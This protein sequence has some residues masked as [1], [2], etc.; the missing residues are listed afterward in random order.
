[1]FINKHNNFINFMYM[2]IAWRLLGCRVRFSASV[3]AT[4]AAALTEQ[5]IVRSVRA[6][7][8]ASEKSRLLKGASSSSEG[9]S[10]LLRAH[11]HS[12]PGKP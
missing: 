2:Y 6:P 7:S 5:E 12:I 11:L 10:C 4:G 8:K 3:S 9:A 1:M